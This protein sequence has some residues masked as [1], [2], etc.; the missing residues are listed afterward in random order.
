LAARF[1]IPAVALNWLPQSLHGELNVL[2]LQLE[3][4]DEA[5]E[6]DLEDGGDNGVLAFPGDAVQQWIALRTAL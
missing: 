3:P 4:E 2:G 5:D 1:H 6:S